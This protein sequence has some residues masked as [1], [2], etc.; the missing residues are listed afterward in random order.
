MPAFARTRVSHPPWL[1][2]L[3]PRAVPFSRLTLTAQ[4]EVLAHPAPR[5]VGGLP[6]V[7]SLSGKVAAP[8]NGGNIA[9]DSLA[10]HG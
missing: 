9:R 1:A 10:A 8:G 5:I 6:P 2:A 7:E 3:H 4:L